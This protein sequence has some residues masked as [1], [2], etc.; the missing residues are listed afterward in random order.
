MN[1][2]ERILT[3]PPYL[4][5]SI[6]E[7][8]K[9]M[10]DKGV[11]VIDLGVGD[12]DRPTPSH[13]VESMVDA[14]R[15]PKNH[16]YPSYVGL[17]E[18]RVAVADWMKKT[19]NVTVDP[20][21]QVL[22]LLGSKE[23]VAHVPFAFINPGDVVLCPNPG[24][25]VYTIGTKFACGVPYEMPLLAKNNFLPD[26]DAIPKDV[27]K[28]AKLLFINYPNNPT[29]AVA[30]K[31]FFEKTVKFAKENDL[32]VVHDNAYSEMVYDDYKS[33]S[34]FE[35]PGAM[36]VGIEF[37]S[38]SKTYNM[39]GWRLGFAVGNKDLIAAFGKVKSNI[40]SGAFDAIQRAGITALTSSQQCVAEMNAVYTQRRN[41]L[42]DGLKSIGLDVK[43]QK[44][45]FYVWA[46]VPEG[47]DS[48]GFA[49]LLLEEAG[50]VVTPGVGFG[51]SGE[52]FVRFALTKEVTRI[53]EAVERMKKIK[54]KI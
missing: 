10:I 48:M 4:F 41:V 32:I 36:D 19:R 24:Y 20:K 15:D 50:I 38:M 17:M 5:A 12:P 26:Y 45:T 35:I 1:Y 34:F 23:G 29:G 13:I 3:L 53:N 37:Y 46:P 43:P 16:Q 47:Y 8:K 30:D 7:S 21:T 49:K 42:I 54:S 51:K 31:A 27:L 22:T 9:A 33:P 6:D 25:P 11:D 40:D 14:V 28:K 39:T 44:A 2:S 52:G 18:F